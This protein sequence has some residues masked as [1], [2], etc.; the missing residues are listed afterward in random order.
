MNIL[1]NLGKNNH[2][3]SPKNFFLVKRQGKIF[4]KLYI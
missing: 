3:G 1:G 4:L 2:F